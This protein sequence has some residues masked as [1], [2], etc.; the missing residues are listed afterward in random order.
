ME[1]MEFLKEN[2]VSV[3][4]QYPKALPFLDAY[5]SFGHKP[6]DFLIASEVQNEV[7]SLPMFP[8]LRDEEIEYIV[9]VLDSYRSR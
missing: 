8:E 3:A 6:Q 4:I 2:G 7:M 5:Q 9:G 1:I